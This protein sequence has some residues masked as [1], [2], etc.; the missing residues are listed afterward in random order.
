[1]CRRTEQVPINGN[2]KYYFDLDCIKKFARDLL[3]M[4]S[5]NNSKYNKKMRLTTEDELHHNADTI[6]H[7]CRKSCFNKVRDHFNETGKN[8]EGQN[9][10]M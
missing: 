1:M 7:I 9:V 8:I 2:F 5:E 6:R 10:N 3:E 4:E